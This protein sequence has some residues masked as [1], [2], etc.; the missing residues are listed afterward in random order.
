M[1]QDRELA[2]P[3][4]RNSS[5]E[6]AAMNITHLGNLHPGSPQCPSGRTGSEGHFFL[7]D[8]ELCEVG[9]CQGQHLGL[10]ILSSSGREGQ[11][12]DFNSLTGTSA[13]G[14]VQRSRREGVLGRPTERNDCWL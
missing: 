10:G 2:I 11:L 9:D 5:E 6:R 4:S 1:D 7:E 14:N 8:G 12:N 13:S 3:S